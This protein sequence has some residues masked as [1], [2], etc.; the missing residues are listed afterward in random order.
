MTVDRANDVL[1]PSRDVSRPGG[2]TV[3]PFPVYDA[4][5]TPERVNDD[6]L[7]HREV[8]YARALGFRR[9]DSKLDQLARLGGAIEL[10][11][12]LDRVLVMDTLETDQV[13]VADRVSVAEIA[14]H[15]EQVL[16]RDQ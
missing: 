1:D 10:V 8:T 9:A 11:V 14:R 3:P 13:V 4:P 12:D 6:S 15:R 5:G 16:G 7:V 2:R